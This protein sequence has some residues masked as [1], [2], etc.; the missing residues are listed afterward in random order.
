MSFNPAGTVV[1]VLGILLV[2]MGVFGSYKTMFQLLHVPG[3][4]Q[5]AEPAGQHRKKK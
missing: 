4:G 5:P 3:F 1:L 2:Y